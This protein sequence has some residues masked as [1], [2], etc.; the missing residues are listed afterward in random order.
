MSFAGVGVNMFHK[1]QKKTA[2]QVTN[3]VPKAG[4][5]PPNYDDNYLAATRSSV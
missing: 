4:I 3:A 2:S 1:S 5:M